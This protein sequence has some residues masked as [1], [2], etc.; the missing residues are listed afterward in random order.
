[1]RL[2]LVGLLVPLLLGRSAEIGERSIVIAGYVSESASGRALE[3]A[4]VLVEQMNVAATT[5]DAGRYTLSLAEGLRGQ[6]VTVIARRIGFAIERREVE[7]IGDTV[8]VDFALAMETIRLQDSV[9]TATGTTEGRLSR[10][11]VAAP[12]EPQGLGAQTSGARTYGADAAAGAIRIRTGGSLGGV[13]QSHPGRRFHDP[14]WNTEAYDRIEDNRFLSV[15]TSPLSTFS[16]DVDRAAYGNV[17][18]FI[19]RGQRPPKDAVRIEEMINY[20]TYDAPRPSR[21]HPFAIATEVMDAPWREGHK[22]VRIGLH[23][24]DIDARELP[25]SNLVFLI[26]VSG[27]MQPANKLPLVK[28]SFRMLVQQLRPRDRVAIVVYA[29]AAGVVLPSTSGSHKERILS[30]IDRLE[31]GGSTAGGQGL[32]LAYRIARE[33]HIDGGNNRVILATD[34]DFNVGVSSDAEMVRLVEQHRE[35][36]TFLTVL[37]YGMGNYKDSKLEKISNAGNGNYAYVDDLLEAKKVLVAEFGGTLFTVAKDV[38]LQVEFNPARVAAY[39]LIGYENR[40]LR[41]EDFDDDTKD[42]GEMGAGHSVTA[43]YEVV[44]VGVRSDVVTGGDLRY[45]RTQVRRDAARSPELL[46]VKIRYKEPDG[47]ESRLFDHA[48]LDR[49]S[50]P[51]H[52]FRFAASVAAFGMILRDS[53]HR[54][55]ATIDD[56]LALAERSLGEDEEGYRAEFVRMVKHYSRMEIAEGWR[57]RR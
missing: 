52:D 41:D 5:T 46:Y 12:P 22:L 44:P 27:S 53:E 29:G 57:E 21:G 25:P 3:G 6:R 40:L 1:M 19:T 24:P 36:G 20:F 2:V 50:R 56:V 30:A 37:G 35:Q 31:A 34:G 17:R 48:V 18:R 26:D 23:A 51:S 32:R 16:I 47:L 33:H 13:E 49:G 43:L 38:K 15:E 4:Q 28:Q 39:R 14:G 42:A 10:V 11:E 54:G 9:V 45:Q 7:L 8:R 55:T